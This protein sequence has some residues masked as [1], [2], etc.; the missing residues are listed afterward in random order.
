[1]EDNII[2][3]ENQKNY[4]D[5][6]IEEF[7]ELSLIEKQQQ[8]VKDLKEMIAS[9]QQ[10]C[11]LSRIENDIII[12]REVLDINKEAYSEDDYAEAIYVYIQT[13]KE[14][15]ANFLIPTINSNNEM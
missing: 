10:L 6:F 5:A 14:I 4:F 13:L 8:I 2:N 12:N 15:T 7:K 11:T 9:Y 1:M 3:N